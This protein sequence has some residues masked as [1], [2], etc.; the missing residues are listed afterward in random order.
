MINWEDWIDKTL[1]RVNEVL[2][3]GTEFR[4]MTNKSVVTNIIFC[5]DFPFFF[6]IVVQ[7]QL[8]PFSPHHSP[9]PPHTPPPTLNPIP[10]WL[11]PCVLYTCSL[12]ILGLFSPL[13][14]LSS[15]LVTISLFFISMSLLIFCLLFFLLIRFHIY[16]RSYSVCLSPSGLFH[17]IMLS[18][19]IHAVSKGRSSFFLSFCCI[20]LHCLNVPSFFD[21][22]IHSYSK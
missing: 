8:S 16:V 9:L 15:L 13:S 7:V 3:F 21:P 12:T 11:C 10:L 1:A 20:V 22:L 17:S 18:S 2:A 14:S 4:V 5:L 6:L 19:S